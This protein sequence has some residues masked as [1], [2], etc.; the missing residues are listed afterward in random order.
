MSMMDAGQNYQKPKANKTR[1]VSKASVGEDMTVCMRVVA[2]KGRVR[3][4]VTG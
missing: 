1:T 2:S 3:V 4:R